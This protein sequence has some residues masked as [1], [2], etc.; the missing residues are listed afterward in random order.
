MVP[1][2]DKVIGD[3][4]RYP[5]RKE[6][7]FTFPKSI[8]L[9]IANQTL[10]HSVRA[11]ADWVP[12]SYSTSQVESG[13]LTLFLGYVNSLLHF[14]SCP[15]FVFLTLFSSMVPLFLLCLVVQF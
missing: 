8:I 13:L 9:A 7:A 3:L 14:S 6:S 10:Q 5:V 12:Q 15:D 11:F 2:N 1:N 4:F